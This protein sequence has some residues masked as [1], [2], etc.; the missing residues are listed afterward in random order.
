MTPPLPSGPVLGAAK[1]FPLGPG[2]AP[3]GDAP[4]AKPLPGPVDSYVPMDSSS[5][6]SY[7]SVE[8]L[9]KAMGDEQL[10]GAVANAKY[11]PERNKKY[12]KVT[13][14]ILEIRK[15]LRGDEKNSAYAVQKVE[16]WLSDADLLGDTVVAHQARVNLIKALKRAPKGAGIDDGVKAVLEALQRN[17][18]PKAETP[19]EAPKDAPKDAPKEAPKAE[20]K[21]Q[22]SASL[23]DS[24]SDAKL[25]GDKFAAYNPE[26]NK[27][28][29]AVTLAILEVRNFA[30]GS[31]AN[32]AQAAAKIAAWLS[33]SALLTDSTA[34]QARLGL[35]QALGAAPK[36]SESFNQGVAEIL[37]ALKANYSKAGAPPQKGDPKPASDVKTK[38]EG[39][40]LTEVSVNPK[41]KVKDKR[42]DDAK[43]FSNGVNGAVKP[44]LSRFLKKYDSI[45]VKCNMT[46]SIDDSTGQVVTVSF[47]DIKLG[48]GITSQDAKELFDAIAQNIC[49]RFRFK[50]MGESGLAFIKAPL[51]LIA[52]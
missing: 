44:A 46:V 31:S 47:K 22:E 48:G 26:R 18:T 2:D 1:S 3:F 15:L 10:F 9:L 25:F 29:L 34:H 37:A 39:S 32:A 17:Y 28:Y 4:E 21:P 51:S 12:L 49:G 6:D 52:Q 8:D 45:N 40:A 5:A 50:T 30:K 16:A 11:Q 36:G 14:A 38:G 43:S 42:E 41:G 20:A 23:A 33:D 13:V 24:L 27:K 35:I 19:K 7:K